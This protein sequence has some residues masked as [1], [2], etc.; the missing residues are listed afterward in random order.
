MKVEYIK[1]FFSTSLK[2]DNDSTNKIREKILSNIKCIP[3]EFLQD[4]EYGD[5]WNILIKEWE[6]QIVVISEGT[7]YTSY[8]IKHKGG[9]RCSYDF[10]VSFYNDT[11]LVKEEKIEFKYG[12]LNITKIPQFLSLQSRFPL[13]TEK[14]DKFYYENYLDEYIACDTMIT[15]PKPPLDVY[16][17]LVTETSYS[18]DSFF[19]Q[20]IMFEEN[21]KKEKKIIVNKSIEH[22]LL[23]YVSSINIRVFIEKLIETQR[24]KIYLLWYKGKF[25]M[26]KFVGD[27]SIQFKSIKNK[28]TIDL[29]SSNGITYKLLLR[30]RNHKG[31]LN[32][33]WQISMNR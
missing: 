11:I 33:A 16:L 13:F 27:Y 4:K 24:D 25:Y 6:S 17:K 1:T 8:E 10:I 18:V 20:L 5:L 29:I 28:N 19:E 21:N 2:K 14:Y 30:W 12:A 32:P 22:Y 9:R 3:T 15:E 7:I 31:I 26:D 23:K